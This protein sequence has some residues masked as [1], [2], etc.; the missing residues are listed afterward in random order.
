MIVCPFAPFTGAPHETYFAVSTAISPLIASLVRPK[1]FQSAR[2]AH[3][4]VRPTVVDLDLIYRKRF[5]PRRLEEH[6]LTH[7]DQIE[8]RENQFTQLLS[9]IRV[10]LLE[11]DNLIR[12]K[13]VACLYTLRHSASLRPNQQEVHADHHQRRDEQTHGAA[14]R[15][16]GFKKKRLRHQEI[17]DDHSST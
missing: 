6:A 7:H 2:L 13:V 9:V 17:T 5:A 10:I 12:L 4:R 11:E 8:V 14:A 1:H 16:G 3:Y 15:V